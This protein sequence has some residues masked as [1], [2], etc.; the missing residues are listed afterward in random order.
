MENG[1]CRWPPDSSMYQSYIRSLEDKRRKN[2][3]LT[4]HGKCTERWFLLQLMKK[5]AG[6]HKYAFYKLV[7][8][9]DWYQNQAP[10]AMRQAIDD[11]SDSEF[12]DCDSA[13]S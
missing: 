7:K 4:M 9:T 6:N 10:R 1:Q 13:G 3:L 2:L 8:N 11:A 5:Y 12:S